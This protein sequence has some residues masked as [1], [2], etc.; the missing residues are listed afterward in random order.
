MSWHALLH[1]KYSKSKPEIQVG[2]YLSDE[3]QQSGGQVKD[4]PKS[5]VSSAAIR[6]TR[7]VSASFCIIHGK[8]VKMKM[9]CLVEENC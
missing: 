1:S 4:K 7:L 6:K 9:C 5:S 3:D 2:L 8:L